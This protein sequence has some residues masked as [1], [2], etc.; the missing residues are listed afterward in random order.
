MRRLRAT[1]TE[2]ATKRT[3][4]AD[5]IGVADCPGRLAHAKFPLLLM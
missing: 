5:R 1:I 4:V 2:E 3:V